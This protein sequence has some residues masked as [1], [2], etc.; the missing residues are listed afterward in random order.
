M[1]TPIDNVSQTIFYRIKVHKTLKKVNINEREKIS[2]SC[3][4]KL[5]QLLCGWTQHL[6]IILYGK[7]HGN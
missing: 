2:N 5:K 6:F 1:L 7:Q 3:Q 4:K